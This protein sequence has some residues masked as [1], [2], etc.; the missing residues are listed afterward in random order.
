MFSAS[1]FQA[2]GVRKS[3]DTVLPRLNI[4]LIPEDARLQAE[5]KGHAE[6]LSDGSDYRLGKRSMG[7]AT[8]A[9]YYLPEG[10]DVDALWEDVRQE[11]K[12]DSLELTLHETRADPDGE[13]RWMR[14]QIDRTDGQIDAF[15]QAVVTVLARWGIEPISLHS[16]QYD[17]HV[18]L[19]HTDDI[20][21]WARLGDVPVP[22][23][24]SFRPVLGVSSPT[25]ELL[26]VLRDVAEH[27]QAYRVSTPSP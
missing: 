25:G 17:P 22:L 6:Y 26:S 12:T 23:R 4:A 13:F 8:L 24:G 27:R 11:W 7:H 21:M 3:R 5:I 2:K 16:E 15:H 20:V 18:T 1:L 19:S 10:V 9:Q 14:F